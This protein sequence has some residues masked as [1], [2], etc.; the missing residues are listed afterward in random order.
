M[1]LTGRPTARGKVEP[2]DFRA[3]LTDYPSQLQADG[4]QPGAISTYFGRPLITNPT[5]RNNVRATTR[6]GPAP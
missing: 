3:Q 6:G 4:L 1:Q 5:D 2:P